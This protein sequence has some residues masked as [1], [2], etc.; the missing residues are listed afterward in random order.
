MNKR[1][2]LITSIFLSWIFCSLSTAEV[3]QN[4]AQN[5]VSE[6]EARSFCLNN[7]FPQLRLG[8]A[9]DSSRLEQH[10]DELMKRYTSSIEFIDPNNKD[11]FG[12]EVLSGHAE[13]KSYY[14]S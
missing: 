7:W 4:P 3:L 6:A 2:V 14:R 9:F 12:K 13:V 5:L 8:A 1:I 11:H 10:L